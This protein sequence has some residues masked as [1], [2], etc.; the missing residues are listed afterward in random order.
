[1][2][3]LTAWGLWGTGRL[4]QHVAEDFPRATNAVLKA[5]GSR[6]EE[7]ARVFARDHRV[8]R[9]VAGLDALLKDAELDAIFVASPNA[10]HVADC[11]AVIAAGKA[12]VCEKPFALDAAGARQIAA[13]ARARG[14]F[15]MEAMWTRFIPS[16]IEAKA[17]VDRGELGAVRLLQGNF[18]Y[19]VAPKSA[20]ALFD[21]AAG[22][23]AL[24]DRG[25]YL[26]SLA[27]HL[28]GAPEKV[29][30]IA[31]FHASG[32]DEQSTYQLRFA[33]GAVAAFSASFSVHGSNE[34]Q[35]FGERG[36]ICLHDPFYRAHRLSYQPSFA[37]GDES[38]APASR[39]GWKASL[40][41][42]AVAQSAR[43]ALDPLVQRLA[44]RRTVSMSFAGHGYQFELAEASRCIASG[45]SES[46]VMPLADSVAVMQTLDEL[47]DSFQ[48][49]RGRGR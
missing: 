14:V 43:A 39:P 22:G 20:P 10:R 4:A 32:V 23:G 31:Q 33:G 48:S 8:E 45:L 46:P 19:A 25:V 21:P 24:L 11:V 27:Q 35:V 5:V 29:D 44:G 12:V 18:A 49:N 13:A 2:G 7:R 1:V 34:F 26:I 36:R 17:R 28:L 9:H 15:C 37:P 30:A 38:A 40:R 47:R 41:G 3:R 16:V 6:S 42:S